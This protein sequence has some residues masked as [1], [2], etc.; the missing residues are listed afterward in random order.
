MFCEITHYSEGISKAATVLSALL[1]VY[2]IPFHDRGHI[3]VMLVLQSCTDPLTF[4]PD[5][6]VRQMQHPLVCVISAI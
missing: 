1:K 4:C 6:P 5:C 3:N 2:T